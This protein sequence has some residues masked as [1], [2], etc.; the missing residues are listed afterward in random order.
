MTV[1]LCALNRLLFPARHPLWALDLSPPSGSGQD[2]ILFDV[3]MAGDGSITLKDGRDVLCTP[4]ILASDG[5]AIG[6][7][8]TPISGRLS[9]QSIVVPHCPDLT[10]LE[11]NEAIHPS[12]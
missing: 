6:A 3:K 8:E 2:P 1:A 11:D 10:V 9:L 12:Q 5:A 7:V 4:G